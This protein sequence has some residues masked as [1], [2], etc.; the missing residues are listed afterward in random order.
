M[1][2]TVLPWTTKTAG[3]KYVKQWLQTRYPEAFR[4]FVANQGNPAV[5]PYEVIDTTVH[6]WI[7]PL[8]EQHPRWAEKSAGVAAVGTAYSNRNA[9]FTLVYD[10]GTTDLISYLQCVGGKTPTPRSRLADACRGAVI[11]QQN[12]VREAMFAYGAIVSCHVCGTE[13]RNG[14]NTEMDHHPLRFFEILDAWLA[15]RKAEPEI[16][17]LTGIHGP[18]RGFADPAVAD[19]WK[20]FHKSKAQLLAICTPCHRQ[21][22]EPLPLPVVQGGEVIAP[23][24]RTAKRARAHVGDDEDEFDPGKEEDEDVETEHEPRKTKRARRVAKDVKDVLPVWR[25]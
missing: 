11:D 15:E 3:Y 4:L 10:N 22:I 20:A 7:W 6:T 25:D 2:A 1:A 9:S 14:K 8:L 12:A 18:R 17:V 13:L 24:R 5:K 19:E 23:A 16:A 21:K